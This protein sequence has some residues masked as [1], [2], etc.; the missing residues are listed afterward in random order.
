ME[1]YLTSVSGLA[2]AL[3]SIMLFVY[4]ICN[5]FGSMLAGSLLTVRPLSTVKAFP[6]VVAAIYILLFT[7]G[8]V[9]PLMAV[10]TVIWGLLG[11]INANINQ[12][13]ISRAAPEAPDFANGLFLT[14]ANLGCVFGTAGG[15]LFIDGFGM[16]YVVLDGL[17]FSAAAA[18]IL[19]EQS[20]RPA[21]NPL[22]E[23]IVTA[24]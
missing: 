1:D 23:C 6:F 12:F 14:A 18:I 3:V 24:K 15:G 19:W 2:P 10:L 16:G 7:G 5:I 4:G 13:R 11:G 8:S 17:L 20:Y 9:W 21:M 22:K